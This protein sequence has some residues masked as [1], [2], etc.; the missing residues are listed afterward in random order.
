ML[1]VSKK[2][3]ILKDNPVRTVCFSFISVIVLGALLLMLPISSAVGEINSF[4]KCLF[5]ATS[6]TCVAG[7]TLED[8]CA[9]WS[10]FGQSIIVCLIQIGGLG[11][12]TFSSIFSQA[13]QLRKHR[14][15]FQ[16][17]S[18]LTY[19]LKKSKLKE[20]RVLR[21]VFLEISFSSKSSINKYNLINHTPP[22]RV[23]ST[24]FEKN[25][26]KNS[27]FHW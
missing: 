16:W 2:K 24:F 1:H 22:I 17:A 21:K 18:V 20:G 13:F 25:T 5:T 27:L 4:S 11:L 3:N 8:N 7:L 10:I 12:V 6:A 14:R 23:L 26:C 15:L 19:I 9:A